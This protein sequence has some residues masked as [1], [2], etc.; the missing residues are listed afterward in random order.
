MNDAGL[1]INS[2]SV[3]NALLAQFC[4]SAEDY[5][6]AS[7]RYDWVSNSAALASPV[8]R[9]LG[10]GIQ[11]KAAIDVIKYD[12]TNFAGIAHS[13]DNINILY[14]KVNKILAFLTKLK[15]PEYTIS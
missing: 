3:S 14:D 10:T 1:N 4:D 9:V 13:E 8:K 12:M 15:M 7:T 6:F 5:F 2:A 11:A